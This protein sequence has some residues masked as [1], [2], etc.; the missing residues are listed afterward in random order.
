[1][2][3]VFSRV[4]FL[5]KKFLL[6]FASV[7][8]LLAACS[9][10]TPQEEGLSTQAAT[11][12]FYVATNGKDTNN[13]TSTTTPLATVYQAIIKARGSRS[14]GPVDIIVAPGTY[15]Q[16]VDDSDDSLAPS[17]GALITVKGAGAIVSGSDIYTDWTPTSS[18]GA[19]H[20]HSWG[21][22]WGQT[23]PDD[24]DPMITRVE[25]VFNNGQL[26]RQVKR[27]ETLT[28]NT[29]KIDEPNGDIYINVPSLG[30]V[31]VCV[32]PTL[33]KLYSTRNLVVEGLTFQHAASSFKQS[34][35]FAYSGQIYDG[36]TVQ[37]NG[38]AGVQL[39]GLKSDTTNSNYNFVI[40]NS[41]LNN[42][43][44]A[45]LIGVGVR[46]TLVEG[47]QISFN[48]WRGAWWEHYGWDTGN[49]ILGVRHL[50]LRNN[51]IE[52]N[53]SPGWWCDTDCMDVEVYG[54]TF[55]NNR[56]GM[57]VELSQ[58]PFEIHN[59]T[60][61]GSTYYDINCDLVD[62]CHVKDNSMT[63]SLKVKSGGTRCIASLTDGAGCNGNKQYWNNP[64]SLTKD[65]YPSLLGF[66]IQRNT[67]K[68]IIFEYVDNNKLKVMREGTPNP[69]NVTNSSAT[70]KDNNVVA[71]TPD[72]QSANK[73][74]LIR[75]D[76]NLNDVV[77]T[78]YQGQ[79]C[80]RR[81]SRF[82]KCK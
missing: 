50:V 48:N 58:G 27:G 53:K 16:A 39:L 13:G 35:V 22:N 29:F 49:K 19:T 72:S 69:E 52:G 31:E 33:W 37:W 47:N 57:N 73:V 59:N 81:N 34:A 79:Q 10:Q 74:K 51:L 77:T 44:F 15:R 78:Y 20:I 41:R 11:T 25:C 21:F 60:F 62:G 66:D 6:M 43:G 67:Y 71:G 63:S 61:T 82:P 17:K 56:V 5:N 80:C 55:K 76:S 14:S 32:R 65:Y 7:C 28:T 54:N 12:T 8:L 42:N 4:A 45:G 30:K 75:K 46:D 36:I 68:Q 9:T 24:G 18:G 2:F 40:R 64:F 3:R 23:T 26:L 70:I 38:Q 1:M